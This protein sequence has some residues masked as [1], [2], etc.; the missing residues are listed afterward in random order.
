M[1][2]YSIILADPPWRFETWSRATGLGRSADQ[3]YPTMTLENI[4]E[5]PVANLIE[6]NCALF[7]WCVWPSI[8]DAR[9]VIEAWG[10]TYRTLAW[11]WVKLNPRG[12]GLHLGLGFY[13]RSNV[14]PCLL[15]VKGDMPVAIRSEQNLL[16][17]PVRGHS[18]K[19]DEQYAKIKRL[20][21]EGKRLELFARQKW[22]DWDCWG[23]NVS[24]SIDLDIYG[25]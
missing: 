13:T 19:P 5:L 20:Y 10:F 6:D 24:E 12:E 15:A 7:L 22:P 16:I 17:A 25:S 9:K 3:Y 18:Q 1:D 2:K 21:P 4:C 8:F 14:E 11:E 23:N